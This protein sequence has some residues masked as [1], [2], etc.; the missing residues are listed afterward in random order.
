[1]GV[2]S[3]RQKELNASIFGFE[4]YAPLLKRMIDFSDY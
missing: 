4:V 3:V 2:D 1:M